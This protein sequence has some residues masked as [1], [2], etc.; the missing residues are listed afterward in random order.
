MFHPNV[1][2]NRMYVSAECMFR[3]NVCF[4]RMYH[5]KVHVCMTSKMVYWGPS[6]S[7]PDVTFVSHAGIKLDDLYLANLNNWYQHDIVHSDIAKL[8]FDVINRHWWQFSLQVSLTKSIFL[9]RIRKGWSG[10]TLWLTSD[11][12][13]ANLCQ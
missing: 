13:M 1:C 9:V 10:Y 6:R 7:K 5:P 2:F 4:N 11:E 3:P 8:H 12:V